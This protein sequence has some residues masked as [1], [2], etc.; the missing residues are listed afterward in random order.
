[1]V[2]ERAWTWEQMKAAEPRLAE[3]EEECVAL[4]TTD[5]DDDWHLYEQMK[6]RLK[7]LVGWQRQPQHPIELTT[8]SAY[9]VA[10]RN[11]LGRCW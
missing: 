10:L 6:R 11:T 5:A 9:E 8:A 1:M 2:S 3:L 7:A 4:R